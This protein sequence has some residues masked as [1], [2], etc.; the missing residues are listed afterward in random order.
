MRTQKINRKVKRKSKRNHEKQIY[1]LINIHR[2]SSI[3]CM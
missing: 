3:Q 1:M 2:I